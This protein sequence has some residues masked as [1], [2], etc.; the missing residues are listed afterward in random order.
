MIDPRGDGGVD[1]GRPM[2]R[3]CARGPGTDLA[4]NVGSSTLT[5]FKP[6]VVVSPTSGAPARG[7]T[8]SGSGWPAGDSI[9]VQIGS[10]TFD[11]DVVC[12]L[13]ASDDGTIAGN[14]SG[15]SCQVP[16]VT[17]GSQPLVAI[18]EQSQGVRATG[19][20]FTVT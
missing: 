13:T 10:S 18:D 9:F 15:N 20:N 4:A 3:G 5:I 7:L 6:T 1:R 11:A 2:A 8:V 12:V 16:N 19:A 17:T 14:Q